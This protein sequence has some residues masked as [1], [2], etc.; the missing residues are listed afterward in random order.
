MGVVGGGESL[1]TLDFP[2]AGI[3]GN[4]LIPVAA[5]FAVGLFCSPAGI[6]GA[7]YLLPFQ[8]SVLGVTGPCSSATNMLY[9]VLATPGGV[10]RLIRERR[11]CWPLSLTVVVGSLPGIVVGVVM[12]ILYL[13]GA[14]AFRT[15]AGLFLLASAVLLVVRVVQR[16]EEDLRNGKA[17]LEDVYFDLRWITWRFAGTRGRVHAIR[18][19]ITCFVV[20]VAAGAYGIGGAGLLVPVLVLFFRI[21]VYIAAGSSLLANF[22]NSG[23]GAV[24]YG[25]TGYL[26]G[27]TALPDPGLA[28]LFAAGGFPGIYLGVR[29]QKH[30]PSRLLKLLLAILSLA[31]AWR[32]LQSAPAGAP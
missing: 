14:A 19:T 31:V 12:R 27:A 10:M 6:S 9:N 13:P 15:F 21:P 22:I 32:Y 7:L 2:I 24:S 30:L 25:L 20:G 4:P 1:L 16:H 3:R 23:A 11:M 18:L 5:G 26:L 28:V 29:L 17:E 8:L